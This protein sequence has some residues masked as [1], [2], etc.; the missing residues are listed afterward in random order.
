MKI[1]YLI[2]MTDFVLKTVQTPNVNE[3]ICWEQ[4][5][6][7]LNQ[8]YQYS[9]FLKQKLEPWM[10][11]PC[12][13]DGNILNYQDIK[14]SVIDGTE[15][16]SLWENAKERVLFD[17]FEW[18]V[19]KFCDE[20]MIEIESEYGYLVYDCQDGTFQNENE[21]FFESIEDIIFKLKL[22]DAAKKRINP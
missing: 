2:S 15:N 9:L 14:Q 17:G 11:V 20:P 6:Q 1:D 10:F 18:N 3:A 7:R 5:E 22:T 13:N 12:D 19:A 16:W 8:I 21:V 4:T